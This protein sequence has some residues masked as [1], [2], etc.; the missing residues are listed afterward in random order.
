MLILIIIIIIIIIIRVGKVGK[1]VKK[2]FENRP[3]KEKNGWKNIFSSV[4]AQ[5]PLRWVVVSSLTT[6]PTTASL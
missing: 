6:S 3:K 2:N 4:F 1:V 5:K